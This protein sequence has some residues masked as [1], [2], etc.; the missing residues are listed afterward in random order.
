ME[1]DF[2]PLG[3]HSPPEGCSQKPL[4]DHQRMLWRA[5]HKLTHVGTQ[6]HQ[7]FPEGCSNIRVTRKFQTDKPPASHF[8]GTMKSNS[9]YEEIMEATLLHGQFL[10]MSSKA[11][12]FGICFKL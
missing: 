4:Q 5:G 10:K 3:V 12:W 2:R 11:Q 1:S 9:V 8:Y 7:E 6:L